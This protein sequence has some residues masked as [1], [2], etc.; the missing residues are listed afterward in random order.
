MNTKI[1]VFLVAALS[2]VAAAGIGVAN[3]QETTKSKVYH[4]AQGFPEIFLDTRVKKAE[5]TLTRYDDSVCFSVESNSLPAGAYTLWLRAFANPD[6]LCTDGDRVANPPPAPLPD[7]LAIKRYW[8]PRFLSA[9]EDAQH[10]D[11]PPVARLA[12]EVRERLETA[13]V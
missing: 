10:P 9:R 11:Q 8:Q 1:G 12:R 7:C 6:A 3:A 5:S 2:S 13:S 4:L